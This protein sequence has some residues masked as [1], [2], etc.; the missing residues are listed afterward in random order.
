[1]NTKGQSTIEFVL[2][3][4]AF[5]VIFF[6][7]ADMMKVGYNWLALQ[8]SSN[9]GIRSAKMMPTQMD[10]EE[11]ATK[12]RDEIIEEAGKIGLTL[13]VSD[14]EVDVIETQITVDASKAITLNPVS[15]LI[16]ALGG[17]HSG[18][19]NLRSREVIRNAEL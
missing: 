18:V 17:D 1:M 16:A 9:R 12:I 13:T 14:I 4:A 15:G 11:K 3:L 19:Y 5:A 6:S 7:M 8:Y 2:T 10:G